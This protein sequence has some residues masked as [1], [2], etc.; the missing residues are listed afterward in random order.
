MENTWIS[1]KDRM[2]EVGQ[3]VLIVY[4][5]WSGKYIT[6]AKLPSN[7]NFF[8]RPVMDTDGGFVILLDRVTHWQPLPELPED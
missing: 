2:P 1:M 5:T 3:K 8:D 4:T 7:P 6:I